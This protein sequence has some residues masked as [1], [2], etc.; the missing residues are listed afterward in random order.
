MP[1]SSGTVSTPVHQAMGIAAKSTAWARSAGIITARLGR[2]SRKW[3]ASNE[4][5][6]Y[7]AIAAVATRPTSPGLPFSANAVTRGKATAVTCVPMLLIDRPA[8]YQR[9]PGCV[10]TNR[11][12]GSTTL[13]SRV[14]N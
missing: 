8:Q 12:L 2:D 11:R 4:N 13:L 10:R 9:N 7:G 14:N 5:S 1:A 6:R 3:P